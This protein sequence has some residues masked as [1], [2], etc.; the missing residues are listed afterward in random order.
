MSSIA[1]YSASVFSGASTC[2]AVPVG[3]VQPVD[4]RARLRAV[5]AGL[6]G[7]L[8]PRGVVGEALLVELLGEAVLRALRLAPSHERVG[9]SSNAALSSNCQPAQVNSE[10]ACQAAPL[11][12]VTARVTAGRRMSPELTGTVGN[13]DRPRAPLPYG[14]YGYGASV[15]CITSLAQGAAGS[16]PVS[17]TEKGPETR[18]SLRAFCMSGR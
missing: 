6:G 8:Q 11:E 14:I 4:V 17:P 2:G 7:G 18:K 3:P 12:Y 1:W 15:T 5:E 9:C 10:F 16:N 13:R